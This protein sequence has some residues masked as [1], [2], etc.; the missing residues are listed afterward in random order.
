MSGGGIARVWALVEVAPDAPEGDGAFV[1]AGEDVVGV[2]GD[3]VDGRVV[4]LHLAH[5][6]ARV[7][8]P[9]LQEASPAAGDDSR[10]AG[11]E[12]ESGHPVL[13]KGAI[14]GLD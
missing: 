8:R 7:G 6:G 5:E 9:E 11:Q 4:R 14:Y 2:D 3:G 1:V 12:G 13:E 10:G